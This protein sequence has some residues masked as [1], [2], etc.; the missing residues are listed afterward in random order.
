MSLGIFGTIGSAISSL[1]T[2]SGGQLVTA[3]A[4]TAINVSASLI[5]QAL[6]PKPKAI[7]SGSFEATEQGFTRVTRGTTAPHNW[8][9]GERLVAGLLAYEGTTGTNGEYYHQVVALAGHACQGIQE[10][11]FDDELVGTTEDLDG[12]GNV[13]SGR[14]AGK[15][16]I[17]F[18]LGSDFQATDADLLADVA[19]IDAHDR[20]RGITWIYARHEFDRDVYP[21]GFPAIRALVK[22]RLV[23]DYRDTAIVISSSATLLT[24]TASG[25]RTL[26]FN[27]NGAAADT[28]DAS[29]GDFAAD[30]YVAG[31]GITIAGTS[32]NNIS[33]TVATVAATTLTLVPDDALTDE[34]PLSSTATLKSRATIAT[35]SVHGLVAGGRCFIS[36]HAGSTPAIAGEYE[37]IAAPTTSTIT[38]DANVTVAG[39]GGQLRA[40]TWSDN[41]AL[42]AADVLTAPIGLEAL[43]DVEVGETEIATAADVCDEAVN[44]PAA[45]PTFDFTAEASTDWLTQTVAGTARARPLHFGDG[46]QLTT[47]GT[48]PAGLSLATTYYAVPLTATRYELAASLVD[49]R[50]GTVIDITDAGTGTH[51]LDRQS[52]ARYTTNA[53]NAF[54]QRPLALQDAM[55]VPM[56]GALTYSQGEYLIF[57]GEHTGATP[58]TISQD[59]MRNAALEIAPR[60]GAQDIHNAVAGVYTDRDHYWQPTD[61]K[62]ITNAT[63]EAADGGRRIAKAINL[64]GVTEQHR[65]Q[66]LAKLTNERARQGLVV[67]FPGNLTLLQLR[68]GDLVDFDLDRGSDSIFA[69]KEFEV[70]DW[71]FA[72]GGGIDVVMQETASA[73]YDWDPDS[74]AEVADL[75][76]NSNLPDAF[77]VTNPTAL[78]L[79]T[80]VLVGP[81]ATESARISVTWTAP[82]DASVIQRGVIEIQF[83]KSA[84]GSFEPTFQVAGDETTAFVGPVAAGLAYD[85]RVRSVNGLGIRSDTWLTETNFLVGDAADSGLDYGQASAPASSSKDYGAASEAV[86]QS[87]DYGGVT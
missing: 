57:A 58:I 6:T 3:L 20:L 2:G 12:S 60:P 14:Y 18:G 32:S 62:P 72:P 5:S 21:T 63:Y 83:K 17:K 47:T 26:T 68:P 22:G 78:V 33:V 24:T 31:Q 70:V 34:G 25:G 7:S 50:A 54:N 73:I 85:V 10:I 81:D 79:T 15:A 11:W 69:G 55:H 1:F 27:D 29:S 46:V 71:Q 82:A 28:I 38:I 51:T 43:V 67:A 77:S 23:A 76:P 48:L 59:N 61:F 37:V 39:T 80:D 74:D 40:M 53:V 16:R 56:F 66:R 45:L 19:E 44:Y 75:A 13:T 36:G 41:S 49:A 35:G 87:F 52:Q 84:D 86:A 42:C 9:H 65:A 8:I 4:F 64:P 30:G